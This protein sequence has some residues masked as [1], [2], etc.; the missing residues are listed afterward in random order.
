MGKDYGWRFRRKGYV[1]GH[2]DPGKFWTPE[3]YQRLMGL[4][5]VEG[6][7]RGARD[8]LLRRGQA[9]DPEALEELRARYRLRLPLMEE[10]LNR[11]GA[12]DAKIGAAI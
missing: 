2:K 10:S 12:K 5:H 11:Q 7:A 1:I 9:G 4:S 3:E 8:T 6:V